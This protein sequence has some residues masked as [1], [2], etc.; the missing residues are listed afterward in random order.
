MHERRHRPTLALEEGHTAPGALRG[1][2]DRLSGAV[3]VRAGRVRPVQDGEG[4]IT[5]DAAQALLELTGRPVPPQLDHEATGGRVAPLRLQLAGDEADRHD[6]VLLRR[7]QEPGA[8]ALPGG[9]V[10]EAD[11]A[12][13]GQRIPDVRLVV[14]RQAPP[15]ARIDVGEGAGRQAGSFA[16]R[17][18]RHASTIPRFPLGR[19]GRHL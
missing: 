5:E 19:E 13:T 16:G 1:K 15:A 11:P 9:L 6:A 8:R 2:R 17:E 7:V 12:E 4:R 18:S 14:D 10:L 3:Q